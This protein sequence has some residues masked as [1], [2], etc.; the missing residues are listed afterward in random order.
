MKT[1]LTPM[2]QQWLDKAQ[3]YCAREEQCCS[4]VRQK[5]FSWGVPA[6]SIERLLD[7]LVD[8][9]FINEQ[10][11]VRSYCESKLRFQKWGR[12]K[13]AYQLYAKHISKSL[14]A[15][16]LDLV[17]DD[18]YQE[19]LFS[20]ASHKLSSLPAGD[21]RNRERLTAFLLSRGYE[22]EFIQPI[23][24]SLCINNPLGGF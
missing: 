10:R 8:D 24:K 19:I 13:V 14:V 2:E 11:Y 6:D 7:L 4:N 3:R 21:P 9:D 17:P 5:M 16:G 18:Q 23:C 1:D 20:L 15:E 22:M 12:R